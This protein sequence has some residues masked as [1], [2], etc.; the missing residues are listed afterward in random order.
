MKPLKRHPVLQ[1]RSRE[2]H[3]SLALCVRILRTP[4][5]SHQDD[6]EAHIPDLLKHF[7]SE[8]EQFDG[9]W[10]LLDPKLQQ[11]FESDH[12]KLREM[13]ASP[14]HGNSAWN[15]EFAQ[16][17]RDHVRFEERELFPAAQALLD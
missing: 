3:H 12:R 1:E 14:E 2:H 8:E 10:H 16:T 4:S 5:E 15:T 6:I 13:A 9:I 7:E 11:R 17:L